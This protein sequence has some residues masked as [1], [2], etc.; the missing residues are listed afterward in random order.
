MSR[1]A[2]RFSGTDP[3]ANI[4][5]RCIDCREIVPLTRMAKFGTVRVENGIATNRPSAKYPDGKPWKLLL[6]PHIGLRCN[7]CEGIFD[8]KAKI[9]RTKCP[10]AGLILAGEHFHCIEPANHGGPHRNPDANAVWGEDE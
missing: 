5:K 6:I 9:N 7:D 3:Y 8:Q 10:A 2:I 4:F 1:T